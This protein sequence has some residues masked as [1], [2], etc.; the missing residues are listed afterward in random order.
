MLQRIL[1]VF[2]LNAATFAEIEQ[3]Q[4]ATT[5]AAIVVLIV[6]LVAGISAAVGAVAFNQAA[7]GL[8]EGLQDSGISMDMVPT[9]S[10]VGAFINGAVGAILSWLIWAVL[11]YFIGSKLFG[12]TTDMGEMLRVIGFA[13]APRLLSVFSFIPCLGG[14]LGLVGWVWALAASFIGIRE[15]LDLD[16]GKTLATIVIAFIGAFLVSFLL[17]LVL[18]PLFAV[19]S[20]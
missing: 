14:L 7:P 17:G 11:T 3:D 10:P 19:T 9:M 13:Q 2:R 1:G 12:A 5:Q 6:G 8:F 4:T 18:A 16:T 20:F 15:G